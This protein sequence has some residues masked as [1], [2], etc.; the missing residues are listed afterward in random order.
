MIS[1]PKK[2]VGLASCF[3]VFEK[4]NLDYITAIK[5]LPNRNYDPKSRIWEVPVDKLPYLVSKFKDTPITIYY[6]KLDIKQSLIPKDFKFKTKPYSYQLDGVEY[7]L[8]H[9]SFILADDQGLGKTKQSLD[10][11]VLRKQLGQVKQCL[12]ICGVNSLK[13]N[14]QDEVK[15]HTDEDVF[16]LGTR[17]RKNG[18]AYTGSTQD[19]IDDL[20]NHNEFFLIVNIET[21]RNEDFVKELRKKSDVINMIIFDE[22]HHCLTPTSAQSR[23]LQKL[24][25]FKYKVAMTGTP[26][27]NAPLD[28]YVAL[29]WLGVENANFSTFRNYYCTFGGFGGHQVTGYKNL[30][31][32]KQS[33]SSCMLRRLKEDELDL[34]PRIEQVEYVELS[35]NQRKIYNEVR[36]QIRDNIDLIVNSPNPLTQLLRLRQATGDTSILSSTIH[37][38]VKLDRLEQLVADITSCGNK[39]IVFS[40]WTSMTTPTAERLRKYYP[41]IITGE[42]DTYERQEE[43]KRFQTDPK[44]K[45][46]IGTIGAAGT[47]LTLTAASYVFF[48]DLPWTYANYDQAC[49]RAYRIGTK[50]TVNIIS[51]NARGTIDDKIWKLIHTK[52]DMSDFIVD[53]KIQKLTK[54]VLLDLIAE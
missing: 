48:L 52:K 7:G 50:S 12:I 53:G 40:N 34:P 15:I 33:L 10:L 35:E 22:F 44:C 30:D 4:V 20:K 47:G 13:Y 19:K 9:E 29:K 11:A 27:M 43:V 16:V 31:I 18:N 1:T 41:A 36:Q 24:N 2:L 17:Y 51:L 8:N 32:L 54:E 6:D 5:E 28:V 3:I 21:L 42:V 46:L 38:S 14:W 23:G 39:C 45:V 25:D 26:V 37:E 49:C